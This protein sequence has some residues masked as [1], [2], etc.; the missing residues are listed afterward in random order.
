MKWIN[1]IA[2]AGAV[3]ATFRPEL[4][5]VAILGSTAPDWLEY[6][7][8]GLGIR[9]AHRTTTHYVSAWIAG[10]LFGAFLY[11][12]HGV[13]TWFCFGGLSHVLA[14]ALTIA[15]VPLGWWST[16]KFHLFGGRLRTG[17]P[18][19]YFVSGGV[20]AACVVFSLLTGG[21]VFSGYSPFFTDWRGCYEQGLCSALEWRE[22]RMRL[23]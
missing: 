14:D 23:F 5:P 19:E 17:R 4:T 10:L 18:G 15:G 20:V 13:I 21:V 8:N 16:T 22:N 11:D 1:H 6:I 2:I 9:T 3:C 12:W 7:L